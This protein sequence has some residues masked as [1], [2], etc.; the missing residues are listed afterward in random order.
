MDSSFL[1][2]AK[3]GAIGQV[4]GAAATF[5]AAS[6]ALYLA[7]SERAFRL[8]VSARFA[9]I[10]DQ[11]GAIPV[12][13]VEVENIGYRSV[14][15]SGF[16]WTTGYANTLRILPKMLRIRS[17]H[18]MPD[19]EWAINPDFPWTL[20]PGESRST[21]IRRADFI[22]GFSQPHPQDLFRRFPWQKRP[23]LFRHRIGVGVYTKRGVYFGRV[24]SK[25]TTALTEAYR[26]NPDTWPPSE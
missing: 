17:A 12:L 21:H 9:Q 22:E 2:W 6:I 3:V 20:E 24:D 13:S 16:F 23:E 18:Q 8:R 11:R 5:L 26:W 25:V 14:R 19:Y 7:R 15:I 10:V 4:A 1:F